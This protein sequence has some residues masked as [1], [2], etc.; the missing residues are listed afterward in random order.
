MIDRLMVRN[1][2]NGTC[3]EYQR[4]FALFTYVIWFSIIEFDCIWKYSVYYKGNLIASCTVSTCAI[5]TSI[6]HSEHSIFSPFRRPSRSIRTH[7]HFIDRWNTRNAT[8]VF[9]THVFGMFVNAHIMHVRTACAMVICV[10][11]LSPF[12]YFWVSIAHFFSNG[13]HHNHVIIQY[14]VIINLTRTV[15][16]T[17]LP[18]QIILFAKDISSR[19]HWNGSKERRQSELIKVDNR[20]IILTYAIFAWNT[21][22]FANNVLWI[23]ISTSESFLKFANQFLFVWKITFFAFFFFM[24]FFHCIFFIMFFSLDHF[25]SAYIFSS[26]FSK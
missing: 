22:D 15:S 18:M 10:L 26:F 13:H 25:F 20:L 14:V 17:L 5:I 2:W 9:H 6:Y 23:E 7:K 4:S 24:V 3:I 8:F 19:S 16:S 21:F 1:R 12:H 11:T